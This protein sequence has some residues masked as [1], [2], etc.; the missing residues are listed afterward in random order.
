MKKHLII[1]LC[2]ISYFSFGQDGEVYNDYEN[3]IN[4]EPTEVSSS[5]ILIFDF[6]NSEEITY[7]LINN[8]KIISTST[9]NK[10]EGKI[11]K[12]VD[13]STL[14]KGVYIIEYYIDDNKVKQLTFSKL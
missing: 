11:M 6:E 2:F 8:D 12:K 4:F 9:I 13:F 3:L 10:G 1:L 7:K 14:K 5:A